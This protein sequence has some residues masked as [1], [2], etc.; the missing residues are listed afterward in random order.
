MENEKKLSS[1]LTEA[2][3]A[4]N[5]TLE[6]L[7][8]ASNISER[9]LEPLFQDKLE[10]LPS[11]PYLH[12]YILKISEV[13]GLKGEEVWKI[14]FKE[15]DLVKKSGKHDELP[16]NRF[17]KVKFDRR[18]IV[19][20]ILGVIFLVYIIWK[21]QIHFSP[22]PFTLEN[23][24]DNMVVE[25]KEFVLNGNINPKHQLFLNGEQIYPDTEGDFEKKIEL[26]E[27]F[28]ALSFKIKKFLGNEYTIEKQIYLKTENSNKTNVKPSG[29]TILE[30][31]AVEGENKST[32]TNTTTTE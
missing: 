7:S 23:L 18:I 31:Q 15:N 9:F 12:G 26:Q 22:P 20:V 17:E 19:G 2:M 25:A 5:M 14:Y 6:K 32:T 4:K 29:G 24:E 13:L 3:N 1:L 16:K 30:K 21:I 27:G 11:S 8:Q 28:N 10:K